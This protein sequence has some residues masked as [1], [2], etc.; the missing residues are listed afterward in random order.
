MKK[1]SQKGTFTHQVGYQI[2]FPLLVVYVICFPDEK[3]LVH[4]LEINVNHY[5]C[6]SEVT[7]SSIMPAERLQCHI[8]IV[9]TKFTI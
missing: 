9:D 1:L 7:A 8:H 5:L 6:L 4:Y 3:S 2:Y